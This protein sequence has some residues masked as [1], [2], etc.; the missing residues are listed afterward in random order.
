M[1]EAQEGAETVFSD[2]KNLA[3]EAENL[4]NITSSRY[5]HYAKVLWIEADEGDGPKDSGHLIGNLIAA[6]FAVAAVAVS[7]FLTAGTTAAAALPIL[8]GIGSLSAATYALI[9][10]RTDLTDDF[11]ETYTKQLEALE[12]ATG[13][14][15]N[16]VEAQK[17]FEPAEGVNYEQFDKLLIA[18]DTNINRLSDMVANIQLVTAFMDWQKTGS[19]G[20]SGLSFGDTDAISNSPA[21]SHNQT[22]GLG[23][24]VE[25]QLLET[26]KVWVNTEG[27]TVVPGEDRVQTWE[28]K[29]SSDERKLMFPGDSDQFG[30]STL[31]YEFER[32]LDYDTE[33]PDRELLDQRDSHF[34]LLTEPDFA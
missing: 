4:M 33:L 30:E 12:N 31:H 29:I 32:F 14:F 24:D 23:F 10:Q 11:I 15:E 2:L 8:G 21:T 9:S 7:A 13:I 20:K 26:R 22:P 5:E 19:A 3:L 1:K 16:V 18:V 6:T 27:Y 25:A 17:M 34:K 28:I